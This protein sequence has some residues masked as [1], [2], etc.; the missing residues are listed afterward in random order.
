MTA[1]PIWSVAGLT[2][3]TVLGVAAAFGGLNAFLIV[4]VLGVLGFLLGRALEGGFDMSSM[5]PRRQ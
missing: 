3:G 1:F 2:F 5:R 4:L